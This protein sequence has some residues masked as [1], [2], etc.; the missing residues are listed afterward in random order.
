M[1][2]QVKA[3][4]HAMKGAMLYVDAGKGHYIPAKALADSFIRAG[5]EA[6]VEN[7]FTVFDSGFWN[8]I[9][10]YSWRFLLHHPRLEPAMT[11]GSDSAFN[12][13][14]MQMIVRRESH[15]RAFQAWYEKERPDFILSTNF[16]GGAIIP[17]AVR[18]L[19]IDIPVY[20]YLADVFDTPRIG[21]NNSLD[22]M[23]VASELGKANAAKK[24]QDEA[25]LS[26]CSFPIQY[27]FESYVRCGQKEARKKLGL[28]DRFTILCSLGG[29]GIGTTNLLYHLAEAGVDC[30][31]VTI[32]GH[33]SSTE[34][35]FR[36]FREKYPDFHLE[37]RGF[38]DNVPDYL[39]ACDL[40]VGKAGANG[41]MESIYMNRPFIVTEVL[42]PFDSCCAFL[43]VHP[44]G[45]CEDDVKMQLGIIREYMQSHEMRESV[46]RSYIDLPLRFGADEFRDMVIQDTQNAAVK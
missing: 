45:W 44:V 46:K 18:K 42:Y 21:V 26:V 29:E 36:E 40:Q 10:K 4:I 35:K 24:G 19:G 23:Y 20:Q 25:S 22:R 1:P 8:F 2:F 7:L 39:E 33:S 31:F 43:S 38:V 13:R 27:K 9:S 15:I 37:M 5:H 32:G 16:I 6:V 41:V 30:Q 17:S 34:K 12:E 11:K 28:D 3:K 14:L